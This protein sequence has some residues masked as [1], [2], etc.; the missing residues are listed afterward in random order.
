MRPD[1][2]RGVEVVTEQP[3]VEALPA[4]SL[5]A[6]AHDVGDEHVVVDLGV[7]GPGRRMAGHR[8]GEPRGRG[9]DLGAA[10]TAASVH[11]DLVEVGHGGVALGVDDLVH[12]LGPA[13]HAQLCHRL[14][15]ADHDLHARPHAADQAL[16]AER[17]V[18]PAGGEDGSPL[19]Q[20][21]FAV[22]AQP[23]RARA[24]P[25][26]GRLTSGRVVVERPGHRVVAPAGHGVLVVADRADAHHPHP[27]HSAITTF[28]RYR[29]G[30]HVI[31]A[32]PPV[33]N[34]LNS[35]LSFIRERSP[36]KEALCRFGQ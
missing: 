12:V 1:G 28:P 22:Q 16:A 7:A 33:A 17:V 36:C 15:R 11:D 34:V 8:P 10:A 13:D 30:G 29:R 23:R 4:A 26:H 6:H 27:R 3:G 21:H 14:V 25:G 20:V 9:A 31:V 2:G 32:Q 19:V 35:D 18:S 24:A 5:V